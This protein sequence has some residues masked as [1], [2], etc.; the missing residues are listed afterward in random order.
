MLGLSSVEVLNDE[1]WE[2][3]ANCERRTVNGEPNPL[4]DE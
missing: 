1:G 4:V 2:L 3:T